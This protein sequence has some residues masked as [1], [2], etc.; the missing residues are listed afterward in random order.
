MTIQ[1]PAPALEA[2]QSGITIPAH[3]PLRMVLRRFLRH[4]A[5]VVS[6]VFLALLV[7]ACVA[8][9]LVEAW[10]GTTFADQ[11]LFGRYAPPS[12]GH[13]LGQDEIGR[14]VLIRLLYGGRVSLLVGVAAA[15]CAAVIGSLVGLLAGF[16]GGRLDAL[17]MRF[18]DGV[19]AL[20]ILP[21][22]IILS[23]IDLKKLGVPQTIALSD[24]VSLY[25]I[26]IV[27]SLFGWTTV[28]RLVRGGAL[29]VRQ[30]EYVRAA[31]AL[32]A[33]NARIMRVHVLPNVVSPIVVAVTLSIGHLI[34]VES[35][36]SYL[37]V[38]IQLPLPSWGN[39]LVNAQ[40]LIYSA[41]ALAIY[42]GLMIFL[43]VIAFN[44]LGDG[45]QDAL[46]PRA[47]SQKR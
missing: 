46:D 21:F 29:S 5:A 41:P 2:E 42:P 36:L 23:A 13:P 10:L 27:V 17:L 14:D 30:R 19:I 15:L 39:M 24:E 33:S 6:A 22:L 7:L 45:L 25:R 35:T 20:P 32:G 8:A 9:P 1:D 4:R 43:T 40:D 37:G 12:P 16:Y 26:V 31:L 38:G 11:D 44:F 28:A 3:T 34:L 18:T 47:T